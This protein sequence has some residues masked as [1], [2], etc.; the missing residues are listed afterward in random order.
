MKKIHSESTQPSA[1]TLESG[2]SRRHALQGLGLAA[3]AMLPA[4]SLPAFAQASQ[5]AQTRVLRIGNQKGL[6]SLLKARGTLEEKLAPLG[7][8]VTWAEFNAGP[9]Q[10]EALNV[11][12]ID[13]G[14]V[15]EAPP[16]FAQAAGA[17]LAYVAS[18]PPRP[19]LEALIVPKDSPIQSVAD[20]KDKRVAF[21]KGSNV[22]YFLV[23]LL[24]KHGLQYSDVQPVFLPP[25][26]ARAAFERGAVDA[27]LIWDPFLAAAEVSLDARQIADA[28]DVVNNR[29]YY[30]S[31]LD[32]AKNNADV[33]AVVI[34]ELNTIDLWARDN[35]EA[36]AQE[37]AAIF[38]LPLPVVQR[39]LHRGEFGVLPITPEVLGEQQRIAD[40]FL[41]LKLI[42]KALN[43]KEA[44]V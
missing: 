5:P 26:D 19:R 28:K 30:F 15:G 31:S 22:Q 4:W 43:L 33:I 14:D 42:P 35:R 17:P 23:K 40:T 32:Y 27:W 25:A 9:V 37:L 34:D 10:L 39:Y 16:I 41:E 44:A 18:S 36:A 8:R 12:A 38:G 29:G 1:Q 20:L 7:V 6:L 13:F 11:G 3:L 21:N 24:E 2:L